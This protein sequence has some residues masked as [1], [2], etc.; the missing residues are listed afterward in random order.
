MTRHEQSVGFMA[1][2][3][4][5]LTG[6]TGV[7][8][9]TLDPG[10]TNLVTASAYAYLGGMPIMMVTGQKPI[11]KPKQGRFQNIDVCGMMVPITRYTHQFA[12]ADTFRRGHV[13]SSVSQKKRR[14]GP[15]IWS[16]RKIS[17]PSKPRARRSL[18]V[19]TAVHWPSTRL[20]KPLSRSYKK[21]AAQSL[22][23]A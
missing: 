14:P 1:A 20:S 18:R 16:C 11:K 5:R 15:S 17:P 3:Y 8:L 12:L 13:K 10:A 9:P 21:L 23:W 2:T 7:S 4:G 19:C 6:K 22:L